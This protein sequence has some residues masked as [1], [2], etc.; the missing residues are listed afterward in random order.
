MLLVVLS[1]WQVEAKMV[2][3]ASHFWCACSCVVRLVV[4][5]SPG[6]DGELSFQDLCACSLLCL[7][8]S[9]PGALG[10]WRSCSSPHA[11]W[12]CH[13]RRGPCVCGVPAAA[14]Q[15]FLFKSKSE[16]SDLKAVDFGLSDFRKPGE[17]ARPNGRI[18]F[19]SRREGSRRR[20][21]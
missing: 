21:R 12:Q 8:L 16:N 9:V 14:S 2:A 17:A 6:A 20:I 4:C 10:A 18:C 11:V 7:V 5:G 19:A 13:A 1:P 3:L 15:N